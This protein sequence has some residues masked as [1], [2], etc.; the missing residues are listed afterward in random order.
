MPGSTTHP[1]RCLGTSDGYMQ[2]GASPDQNPTSFCP[3]PTDPLI[4]IEYTDLCLI[5]C[6][7]RGTRHS[8]WNLA[9]LL[10]KPNFL[11]WGH[12]YLRIHVI[13]R[14]F[15]CAFIDRPH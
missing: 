8:L 3:P 7:R 2:G 13:L 4:Q 15:F 9:H 11:S 10:F 12:T 6:L 14:A 5:I 1:P